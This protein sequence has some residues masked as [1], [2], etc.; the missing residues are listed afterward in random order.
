MM[1]LTDLLVM[2][3]DGDQPVFTCHLTATDAA[4]ILTSTDADG[5]TAVEAVS[6]QATAAYSSVVKAM[7]H[8]VT[9]EEVIE[10][11]RMAG[12]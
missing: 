5:D 4:T 11:A 1:N 6:S 7:E 8:L 3:Y 9:P 10:R 12:T 2:G